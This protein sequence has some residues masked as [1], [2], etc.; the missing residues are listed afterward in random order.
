[1]ILDRRLSRTEEVT[2]DSTSCQ[3]GE[4]SLGSN[5]RLADRVEKIF[6]A[7]ISRF[8]FQPVSIT[9]LL[10]CKLPPTAPSRLTTDACTGNFFS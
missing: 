3:R 4:P 2:S 5:F 8:S 9:L 1:M 7:G 6:A 10:K